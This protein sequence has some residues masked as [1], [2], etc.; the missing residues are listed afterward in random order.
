SKFVGTTSKTGTLAS[1]DQVSASAQK[2][3][4]DGIISRIQLPVNAYSLIR[5]RFKLPDDPHPNGL[6][7][8]WLDPVTTR[9]VRQARWNE[10]DPGTRAT[11]IIYPLHTGVLGG[12]VLEVVVAFSGLALAC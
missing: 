6:T 12:G 11:T 7:S 4:P 3:Y 1:L 9:V 2:V 10:L 8:V 5:V